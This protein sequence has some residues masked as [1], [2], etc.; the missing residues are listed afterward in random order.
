[1]STF[2][3]TLNGRWFKGNTHIHSTASDGGM[4]FN[5]LEQLYALAGYDF[6]F[7]TD[8]WI[9]SAISAEQRGS[10]LLWLDGVELDGIDSSGANYHMVGLGTF[11][12]IDRTMGMQAAMDSLR[13]QNAILILAHPQWMGNTFDEAVRGNF[14]GVEVYN[15]VCR[16]LNGKGDGAAYWNAMLSVSPN[17]LV[18]AA[19]DAHLNSTDPGWNGGWVVVNAPDCEPDAI[20][21]AIRAGNY[22][23]SCGPEIFDIQYD[24]DQVSVDCSPVQFARLVG[25]SWCGDRVGSFTGNTLSQAS[26]RI[27]PGWPYAY[28]ELEDTQGH[29][30]WTN[31]LLVD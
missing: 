2:R 18:I 10:P 12:G 8:H 26:F 6:L 22:Y 7:R 25:P 20:I 27:P 21:N 30:A 3:Y 4:N 29:R 9:A 13:A 16:W 24:G 28:L 19:D 14:D 11:S 15:H 31:T 5:E 1:M 17:T 23:S